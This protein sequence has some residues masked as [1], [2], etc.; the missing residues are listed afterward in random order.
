[1]AA[2]LPPPPACAPPGLDAL[3]AGGPADEIWI[4]GLAFHGRHGVFEHE[5]RDGCRFSL[6]AVLECDTRRAAASDRLADTVDY[7]AVCEALLAVAAGPS[8]HLLERLVDHMS[9]AVLLRWPAV[10]AVT[11]TLRKLDPPV[12]GPARAVAVRARRTPRDFA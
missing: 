6:D 9:A 8:C 2:P 1:V 4:E 11:L 7:G 10:T 12:P 3:R 5:R